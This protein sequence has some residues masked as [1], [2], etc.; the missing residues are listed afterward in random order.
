MMINHNPENLFALRT[1][2]RIVFCANLC[3]HNPR[4]RYVKMV[5][6]AQTGSV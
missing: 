2:P 6:P 3:L 5:Q 4:H 1:I